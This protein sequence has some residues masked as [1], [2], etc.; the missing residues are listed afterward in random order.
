MKGTP[1]APQCGFSR[2]VIQVL[3][4]QGVD[5]AKM[6][7]YNVLE[8]PE[9]RNSIKEYSYVSNLEGLESGDKRCLNFA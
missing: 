9:L 5:R 3:D 6:N 1:D 8:D 4:M 7:T 2:T